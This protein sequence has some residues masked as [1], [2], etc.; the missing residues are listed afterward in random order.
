MTRWIR[1]ITDQLEEDATFYFTCSRNSPSRLFSYFPNMK[2]ISITPASLTPTSNIGLG[3]LP[4]TNYDFRTHRA[5]L[6]LPHLS[7]LI[8]RPYK[9][10]P[11]NS[12]LPMLFER[13]M[14][15]RP[16]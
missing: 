13:T 4:L 14:T 16:P 10:P 9:C 11:I 1:S 15:P 6:P 5:P 12:A 3:G 7:G 2:W 8:Y